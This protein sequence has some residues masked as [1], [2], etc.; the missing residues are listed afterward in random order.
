VRLTGAGAR[1]ADINVG[2]ARLVLAEVR[3]TLAVV[4]LV[5]ALLA[6][7]PEGTVVRTE[8]ELR[9]DRRRALADGSRKPGAGRIP[10]AVFVHPQGATAALEL[11]LTPK[12]SKDL[13]RIISAYR[14]EHYDRIVWYVLP[15]QQDRLKQIV[16][17]QRADDYIEVRVWH[18]RPVLGKR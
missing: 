2:P 8:R 17:R 9:I 18:T 10:D 13:D 5:E 7:S 1:L 6:G 12:R 16:R 14:Q 4:D 3:H 11:D 15:R